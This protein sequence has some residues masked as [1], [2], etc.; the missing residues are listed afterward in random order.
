MNLRAPMLAMLLGWTR[1]LER[2]LTRMST[3]EGEAKSSTGDKEQTHGLS[4]VGNVSA[5]LPKVRPRSVQELVDEATRARDLEQI[6][7]AL[8]LARAAFALDPANVKAAECLGFA[9]NSAQAWDTS[10]EA[11]LAMRELRPERVGPWMQRV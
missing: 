5:D 9:A 2:V 3:E 11:W 6:E 4:P 7:E 8:R 1:T 10:A